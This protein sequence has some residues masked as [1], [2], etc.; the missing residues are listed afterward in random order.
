MAITMFP[1]GREHGK[2]DHHEWYRYHGWRVSVSVPPCNMHAAGTALAR[3]SPAIGRV[4]LALQRRWRCCLRM[5]DKIEANS[6]LT[7]TRRELEYLNQWNARLGGETGNVAGKTN[8][9]RA[10]KCHQIAI[11]TAS[12]R[13]SS[14]YRGAGR[15]AIA[16]LGTV[17][18]ASPRAHH[19]K[20]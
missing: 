3:C 11:N 4:S 2:A 15:W 6:N 19:G 17:L 20:T 10:S 5:A 1:S 8:P 14:G 13:R 9:G 7:L 18:S 16:S 12:W